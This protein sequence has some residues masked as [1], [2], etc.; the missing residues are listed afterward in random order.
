MLGAWS[1]VS[2]LSQIAS[3]PAEHDLHN[4]PTG[5]ATCACNLLD[6]I[7]RGLH[8]FCTRGCSLGVGAHMK[9]N[10]KRR[11]VSAA[12]DPNCNLSTLQRL[13]LD[14]LVAPDTHEMIERIK[15]TD[16]QIE[17]A[18]ETGP[19]GQALRGIAKRRARAG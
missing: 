17:Q 12:A 10:R 16:K 14:Y 15:S 13:A 9:N 5:L 4:R 19:R 6:T 7:V 8:L 3:A 2:A 11:L 1:F 18:A